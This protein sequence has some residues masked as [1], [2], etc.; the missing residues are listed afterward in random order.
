MR[1]QLGWILSRG[2]DVTLASSPG[3]QLDAVA[4]REGIHIV[5]LPMSREV[6]L[7][8]DI[9]SLIGFIRLLRTLRPTLTHVSTPKA[10]LIGGLAAWITGVPCRVYTLRGLRLETA[11]GGQ[12]LLLWL[13]EWVAC[14][15]AHV[16]VVVSPSLAS[17]AHALRLIS[18]TKTV[19]IGL[20]TS[21]GVDVTRFVSTPDRVNAAK[22][23]RREWGIPEGAPVIGFVGRLAKDKGIAELLTAFR[24]VRHGQPEARL[25]LIGE[26]EPSL[27]SAVLTDIAAPGVIVCGY[28]DDM[29]V[30]YQVM[31]VLALPTYREGFPNVALEAAAA[32]RPVVTTTATGAVDSVL[33]GRS[34]LLVPPHDP[35]ATAAAL[36]RL[37][38]DPALARQMGRTGRE[39]VETE[40]RQE[41]IWEGLNRLYW[42]LVRSWT[43]R[44]LE[45]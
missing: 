25:L 41:P 16:V 30:A 5:P 40:F 13:A 22:K 32:E 27:P 33:D 3:E 15:N 35:S 1:G 7:K 39:W 21:N 37:I 29:S 45:G 42:D 24:L 26:V 23:L 8:A 19:V 6:D 12:R 36:A 28:V 38:E 18:P 10:G 44:A 17:R 11:T 34:G 4:A 2:W 14:R 20:G 43:P 31:D 9:R